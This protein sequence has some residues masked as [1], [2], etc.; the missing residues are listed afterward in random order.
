MGKTKSM[1]YTILIR[2]ASGIMRWFKD[3]IKAEHQE[4]PHNERST[5]S[6]IPEE[7]VG[8]NAIGECQKT[9]FLNEIF[10]NTS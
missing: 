8:K 3:D 7:L 2:Y 6:P 10:R 5:P 9:T 4:T 1:P